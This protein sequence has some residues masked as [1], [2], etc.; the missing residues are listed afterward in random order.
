[1]NKKSER[2]Q[3]DRTAGIVLN[4]EGISCTHCVRHVTEALK[5][6]KGVKSVRVSLEKKTA[7]VEY[8]GSVTSD[9]MKAAVKEAGYEASE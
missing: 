3:D 7:D 1:M 2:P 9:E 5:A 6:L 4:I 8:N